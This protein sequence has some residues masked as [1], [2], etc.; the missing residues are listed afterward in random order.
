M[1]EIGRIADMLQSCQK[2]RERP[3]ANSHDHL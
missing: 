2:R 3:K 1:S